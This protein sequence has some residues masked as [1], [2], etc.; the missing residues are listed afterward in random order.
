MYT[1]M[2]PLRR[3]RQWRSTSLLFNGNRTFFRRG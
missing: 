3:D 1:D 2:S